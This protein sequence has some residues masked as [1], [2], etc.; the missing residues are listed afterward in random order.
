MKS[1]MKQRVTKGEKVSGVRRKISNG[2]G[3]SRDAKINM[4]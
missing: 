4:Y 1:E 3:M 2:E